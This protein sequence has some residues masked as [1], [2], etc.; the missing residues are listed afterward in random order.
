MP[1]QTT[2]PELPVDMHHRVTNMIAYSG[3]VQIKAGTLYFSNIE[4]FVLVWLD[5]IAV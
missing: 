1:A 5:L 2:V 4:C 3:V